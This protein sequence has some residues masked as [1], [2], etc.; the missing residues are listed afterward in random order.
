MVFDIGGG[1][2]NLY[3]QVPDEKVGLIIGKG[4]ATVKSIQQRYN[5][6]GR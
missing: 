3:M 5:C 2:E 1:L 4:G 6:K